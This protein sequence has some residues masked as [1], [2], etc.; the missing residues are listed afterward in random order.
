[1]SKKL[2]FLTIGITL[3]A[4][5][6]LTCKVNLVREI[7]LTEYGHTPV[8]DASGNRIIYVVDCRQR[9]E[10]FIYLLTVRIHTRSRL[11]KEFIATSLS[12]MNS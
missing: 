1:M 7:E 11:P 6:L 3:L 10:K 2:L 5:I 12:D 4:V 9:K 8:F